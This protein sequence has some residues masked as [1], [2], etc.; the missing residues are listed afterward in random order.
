MQKRFSLPRRGFTVIELMV[1]VGVIAILA[2]LILANL[3]TSRSKAEDRKLATE[4]NSLRQA[5]ELYY[6][7]YGYYP[8]TGGAYSC[9]SGTGTNNCVPGTSPLQALVTE[10][11]ISKIPTGKSADGNGMDAN[12]IYYASPGWWN[13]SW[14]YQLQFQVTNRNDALGECNGSCPSVYWTGTYSYSIHP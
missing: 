14:G 11:F 13:A 5:L 6:T 7:K 4:V 12:E 9:T 10:G 3:T 8:P 2:S 1:V